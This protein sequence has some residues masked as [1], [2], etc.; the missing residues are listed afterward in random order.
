MGARESGARTLIVCGHYDEALKAKKTMA[1]VGWVPNAHNASVGPALPKYQAVLTEDAE[2][3]FSS[4]QWVHHDRLPLEGSASFYKSF[5]A[6]YGEPPSYQ[7]AAAYAAGQ[8]LEAAVW[9]VGSIDRRRLREVLSSINFNSIIGRYGVDRTG[10]Q[11]RH[12]MLLV[13]WQEGSQEVVWPRELQTAEPV[14]VPSDP[15]WSN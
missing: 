7:A 11:S 8:I 4:S 15:G 2:G 5:N 14:L 12:F 1:E 10:R 3:V 6:E 13:Q 9:K